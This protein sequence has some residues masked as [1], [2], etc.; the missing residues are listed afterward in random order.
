MKVL[1]LCMSL[2]ISCAENIASNNQAMAPQFEN[3][4]PQFTSFE[5]RLTNG[6]LIRG[7]QCYGGEMVDSGGRSYTCNPG[8]WLVTVDTVNSCT[9]EGCTEVLV[10]PILAQLNVSTGNAVSTFYRIDPLIPVN[11]EIEDILESVS[12]RIRTDSAPVVI[13][14]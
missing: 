10:Q 9:P 12:V 13:F 5:T 7:S 8:N 2:F 1:L 11:S 4:T 6:L 3:D 14:N